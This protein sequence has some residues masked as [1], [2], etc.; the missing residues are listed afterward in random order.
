[1]N[2]LKTF[3]IVCF[4]YSAVLWVFDL[5]IVTILSKLLSMNLS[6]SGLLF[7]EGGLLL[8][9]GGLVEASSSASYSK[10]RELM[11]K[12]PAWTPEYHRGSQ[13]KALEI[14]VTGI[15]IIILSIIS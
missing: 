7:L 1:M 10:F 6:I 9:I 8:A 12:T 2:R 3:P 11:F 4:I 15:I 13:N 5:L 14:I